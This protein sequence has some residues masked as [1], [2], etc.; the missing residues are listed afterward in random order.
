MKVL[1]LVVAAGTL[2]VML[3]LAVPAM[4]ATTKTYHMTSVEIGSGGPAAGIFCGSATISE[5]G[6]VASQCI[7]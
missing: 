2:V 6:H 3:A 1:R 7:V 4:A 5:L